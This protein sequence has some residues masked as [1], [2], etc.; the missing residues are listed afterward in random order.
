MNFFNLQSQHLLTKSN[1]KKIKST[2]HTLEQFFL[3]FLWFFFLNFQVADDHKVLPEMQVPHMFSSSH[4]TVCFPVFISFSS[5]WFFFN[6][7]LIMNQVQTQ[8]LISYQMF[9]LTMVTHCST[10]SSST[11]AEY[12]SQL[13]SSFQSLQ[14]KS[15]K[16]GKDIFTLRYV[17]GYSS[18]REQEKVVFFF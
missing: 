16:N 14:M 1:F 15:V 4:S 9:F 7:T 13:S 5:C 8:D 17:R 11:R 10:N 12:C 18:N 2:K 6:A 3:L